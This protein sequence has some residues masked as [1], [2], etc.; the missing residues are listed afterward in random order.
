MCT[1]ITS[2]WNVREGS[3]G[4]PAKRLPCLALAACLALYGEHAHGRDLHGPHQ[5]TAAQ[6]NLVCPGSLQGRHRGQDL[7]TPAER[8]PSALYLDTFPGHPRTLS[9]AT[10]ANSQPKMDF[11]ILILMLSCSGMNLY[12]IND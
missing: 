8:L 11:C 10:F 3:P 1:C 4:L 6:P 12:Q 7:G 2:H 9:V 5:E